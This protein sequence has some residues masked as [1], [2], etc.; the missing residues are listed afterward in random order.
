MSEPIV[1]D[2]S[3]IDPEAGGGKEKDK[4]AYDTY[5]KTFNQLKAKN[6]AFTD[7]ETKF[8]DLEAT[9]KATSD[10]KLEEDGEL[11]TLLDAKKEELATAKTT[12]EELTGN[13]S[14]TQKTILESQKL[15]AV[16]DLLPGQVKNAKYLDFIDLEK[17]AFD[18]ELGVFDETSVTNA[19]NAFIKDHSELLDMGNPKKLPT[20]APEGGGGVA[21]TREAWLKLSPADR[22]KRMGEAIKNQVAQKKQG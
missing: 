14:V 9:V 15:Q 10:A 1:E 19:A 18:S 6:T 22:K 20:D 12:I 13:L 3:G 4:V 2:P 5:K 16:V 7:L 17:V 21:L 11:R 8:A